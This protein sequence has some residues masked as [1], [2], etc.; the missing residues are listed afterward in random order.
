M[1]DY[2]TVRI[3]VEA[4]VFQIFLFLLRF[5]VNFEKFH[6]VRIDVRLFHHTFPEQKIPVPH[7]TVNGRPKRENCGTSENKTLL[8]LAFIVSKT[9][10]SSHN[11]F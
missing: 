2:C 8:Y 6:F 7:L 1:R 5:E 11:G 4:F 3:T 10:I 9:N